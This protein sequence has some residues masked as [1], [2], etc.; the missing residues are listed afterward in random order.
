MKT[1]GRILHGNKTKRTVFHVTRRNPSQTV[2][3][4]RASVLARTMDGFPLT[5]AIT[6][7][8]LLPGSS[9][10]QQ[11]LKVNAHV[12]ISRH[13]AWV[14][15]SHLQYSFPD[16]YCINNETVLCE[17]KVLRGCVGFREMWNESIE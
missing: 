3:Q 2:R 10:P 16:R 15:Y 14:I 4:Q 7:S 1:L 5:E 12:L 8:Y 13:S 6:E 17:M 11:S 9:P